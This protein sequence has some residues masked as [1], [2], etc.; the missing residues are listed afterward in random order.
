MS[1]DDEGKDH[2]PTQK[3]LDDARARGD[4]VRSGELASAAAVAGLLLSAL[5][6]GRWSLLR[7]GE[8]AQAYLDQAG[9]LPRGA[10]GGNSWGLWGWVA[11]L[12]LPLLAFFLLPGL[13]AALCLIAQRALVFSGAK[14]VPQLSRIDPIA[15][16][17]YRFGRAGLAEFAKSGAKLFA[18]ALLLGWFLASRLPRLVYTIELPAAPASAELVRMLVEFLAAVTAVA[19]LLG[20]LDYLWQ[21]FEYLR[22]NRMSRQEMMEEFRDS[23]GD[24]HVKGQRRQR[25][26]EI[27]TN[28]MI[29]DVH[30]ADVVVVNPTHYAVA[31][32]WTRKSGRAPV[33]M[34]KGVD[35]I[36]ARI[37]EAAA[38]AGVPI[39]SDPPTARALHAAVD[40]GREI[41]PEHSA[42]VAAAIRYAERM[43]KRARERQGGR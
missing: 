23:E 17:R 9:D 10:I 25:A 2:E 12:C 42:P 35:E 33:C 13:G 27:A 34:A 1:E 6:A 30:K 16:A 43:R 4:V 40:I 31:L 20:G 15:N 36:A 39:H 5:V 38:L 3:K 24:P 22:R 8:A 11:A 32:K 41:R 7:F 29:A 21:A 19:I 14:L 26:K 28:R 37:R 18:V